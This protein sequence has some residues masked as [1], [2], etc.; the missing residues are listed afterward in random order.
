MHQIYTRNFHLQN[1]STL[2]QSSEMPNNLANSQT[3]VLRHCW[4]TTTRAAQSFS[5]AGPRRKMF[6]GK[7][8]S[9]S[10]KIFRTRTC[11]LLS[12]HFPNII[13]CQVSVLCPKYRNIL[14][15]KIIEGLP[16]PGSGG[17]GQI[18]P[19]APTLG[20]PGHCLCLVSLRT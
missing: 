13:R 10:V 15:E 1:P 2:V 9:E 12:W 18:A 14:L 3:L 6:W 19:F 16:E 4:G 17:G 8:F 7:T 20:G 11:S 5:G